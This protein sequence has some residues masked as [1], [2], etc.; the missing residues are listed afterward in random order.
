MQS[1]TASHKAR[2]QLTYIVGLGI[3]RGPW[4]LAYT[5]RRAEATGDEFPAIYAHQ[6]HNL[7]LRYSF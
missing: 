7:A 6:A 3:R 4:S 1:L 5:V 2:W